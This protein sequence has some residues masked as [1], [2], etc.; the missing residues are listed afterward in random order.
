[1]EVEENTDE[2]KEMNIEEQMDFQHVDT[3]DTFGKDIDFINIIMIEQK[4]AI[5]N[6]I[7]DIFCEVEMELEKEH[8]SSKNV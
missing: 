3:S 5:F 1:M 8:K 4:E 6:A 2:I 7:D